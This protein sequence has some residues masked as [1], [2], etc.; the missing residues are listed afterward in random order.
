ML[1]IFLCSFCS[2]IV[3]SLLNTS[4]TCSML[5]TKYYGNLNGFKVIFI[6]TNRQIVYSLV[7]AELSVIG[8]RELK[9][10]LQVFLDLDGRIPKI[11]NSSL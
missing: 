7:V 5:E 9:H 6:Q 10:A 8:K 11:I 4:D 3:L 1:D 2:L